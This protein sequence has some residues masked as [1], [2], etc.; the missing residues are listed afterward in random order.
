MKL[1]DILNKLMWVE[2]IYVALKYTCRKG[3][4]YIH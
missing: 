2:L 4:A 3:Y 1:Y